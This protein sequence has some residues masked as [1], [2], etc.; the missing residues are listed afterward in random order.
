M[1]KLKWAATW[2]NQESD[3]APSKDSDQPG[4][5]P[6]W[7]ESSLC[8]QW[9]AKVQCF[10][11]WTVKTLIRLDECPRWS[12]SS[13]GVQVIFLVLPCGGSNTIVL[14]FYS[15][16][17]TYIAAISFVKST[18]TQNIKR[19]ML[20]RRCRQTANSKHSQSC[21]HPLLRSTTTTAADIR[22]KMQ[23]LTITVR[24]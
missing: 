23:Q 15:A 1:I 7:S 4:Q 21:T 22:Y 11:M 13:L 12:E 6:V 20:M 2:Q 9:V 8:A 10:F 19:K 16:R 14:K 3:C 18:R 5:P 24:L 17:Y